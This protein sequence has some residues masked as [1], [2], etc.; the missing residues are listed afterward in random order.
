MVAPRRYYVRSPD[1][2][3][4]TG[5]DNLDSARYAAKAYGDG[6]HLVDTMAQ[7]YHPMAEEVTEGELV[8][9]PYGGWDT[10]RG[11]LECNLIEAIK[12]GHVAIVHAFLAKGADPNGRDE[13]G[14]PALLWAVARGKADIV[15]LLLD[16]GADP[17]VRDADGTSALDLARRRGKQDM[18]ALLG[19]DAQNDRRG[20]SARRE[21]S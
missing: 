19:Q 4:I 14:G 2:R 18:L 15:A 3:Q 1:G 16:H 9:L 17:A 21:G 7:A 12:K 5:F 6:A 10:H 13:H 11:S 8:F 20:A